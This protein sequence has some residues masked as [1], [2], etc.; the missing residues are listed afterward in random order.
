MWMAWLSRRFPRRD[1]R[2]SPHGAR[3]TTRA[4]W[5]ANPL[6]RTRDRSRHGHGGRSLEGD[7]ADHAKAERVGP[8][9]DR[10]LAGHFELAELVQN[11]HRDADR[12]DYPGHDDL[13]RAAGVGADVQLR[14]HTA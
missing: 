11:E 6:G 1:S 8:A 5:S 3:T 14:V 2:A 13:D 9:F 12:R 7:N 10:G 4:A